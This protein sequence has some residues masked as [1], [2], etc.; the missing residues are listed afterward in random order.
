MIVV[1]EFATLAKEI[2]EFVEGVVDIAARGR[3]LGLRLVLA[4]QRPAGV[5]NDRIRANVGVRIALRVNDE[6]D[7]NDVIE[8]AA[9]PRTSRARCPGG[10]YLKVHRD[11]DGVPER[12]R[13]WPRPR[14]CGRRGRGRTTSVS[15]ATA[16]RA[17][18]DGPGTTCSRRSSTRAL[19]VMRARAG[20]RPRTSRGS[21]PCRRW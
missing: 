21:R 15:A 17:R 3:S 20:G 5:I 18:P 10:R 13:R 19:K 8:S 7:S 1:D 12:V 6:A 11:V 14:R 2:P 9:R 4:T 16:P